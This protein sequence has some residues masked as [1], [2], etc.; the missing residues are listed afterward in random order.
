MLDVLF[1]NPI[2]SSSDIVKQL[3]IA[4]ATANSLI[5][6]FESLNILKEITGGKRDRL[7]SFVE[8]LNLFKNVK[9]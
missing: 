4:P 1:S 3:N 8:Y 6:D 2:V 5:Q 7:F 9:S